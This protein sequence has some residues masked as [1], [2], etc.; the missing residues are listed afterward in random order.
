MLILM[1]PSLSLEVIVEAQHDTLSGISN[2][3][4]SSIIRLS[5]DLILGKDYQRIGEK[6][7]H[8]VSLIQMARLHFLK[9]NIFAGKLVTLM[10]LFHHTLNP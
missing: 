10:L 3:I 1:E 7:F 2:L 9:Q 8:Q 4:L 6:D 5:M